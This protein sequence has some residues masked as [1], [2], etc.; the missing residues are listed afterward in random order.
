MGMSACLYVVYTYVSV[1]TDVHCTY[2]PGVWGYRQFKSM[3]ND[4][5][6]VFS[7]IVLFSTNNSFSMI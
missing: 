2:F 4:E 5:S 1:Y 6:V 7:A 3:Y